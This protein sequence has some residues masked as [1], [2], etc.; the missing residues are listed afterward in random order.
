MLDSRNRS[1]AHLE[2]PLGLLPWAL[3]KLYTVW[4]RATY[5]FAA[6]GR[7]V[8]VH[9][10]FKMS[11]V[12]APRIKLGN[13]VRVGK[14][15]W[16]NIIPEASDEVNIVIEDNCRISPRTWISAK[17]QIHL[18]PDVHLEPSVLIQDHGHAYDNPDLPIKNQTAMPGG[19][20]RIERG[21]RIG[22]GVAIVCSKGDLILGQHCVVTPN[23]VVVRSAP[24]YSVV[25]GNPARVVERLRSSTANPES[26]PISTGE[27]ASRARLLGRSPEVGQYQGNAE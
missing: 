5:P 19:R 12:M 24:P 22:Q 9:Y 1:R 21:C 23:S 18:E 20:I 3:S 13:S 16:L 17:N 7:S 15:V 25:A 26:P 14:D 27:A 4:L 2:D 10:T 8:S 6:M 11:R